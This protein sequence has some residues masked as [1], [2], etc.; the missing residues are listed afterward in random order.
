MA[1]YYREKGSKEVYT[2]EDGK[3][4]HVK[5]AEAKEKNIWSQVKVVNTG[6][7]FTR[8]TKKP[9]EKPQGLKKRYVRAK[10]TKDVYELTSSGARKVSFAE[11]KAKNIWNQVKVVKVIKNKAQ[12]AVADTFGTGYA[13]RK[14]AAAKALAAEKKADKAES[15]ANKA[16]ETVK[17]L[18]RAAKKVRATA[19][20]KVVE[21]KQKIVDRRKEA[22]RKKLEKSKLIKG[23]WVR[24]KKTKDGNLWGL[25][26]SGRWERISKFTK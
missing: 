14:V 3:W 6:T 12:K 8:S 23:R 17:G 1:N 15:K 10:G 16:K 26:Q 22:A 11:A 5:F 2:K 24:T 13:K 7:L 9:L 20:K 25:L 19:K 4:R 21:T 18:G